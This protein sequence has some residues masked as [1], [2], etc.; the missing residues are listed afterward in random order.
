MIFWEDDKCGRL[1]L[2]LEFPAGFFK[3]HLKMIGAVR[4]F[5]LNLQTSFSWSVHTTT[6]QFS[7]P[8]CL[9]TVHILLISEHKH[10]FSVSQFLTL[11]TFRSFK[12]S[13]LSCQSFQGLQ[14]HLVANRVYCLYFFIFNFP[15]NFWNQMTKLLVWN[16]DWGY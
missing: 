4:N 11:W 6:F 2:I 8:V 7:T 1:F 9:S 3:M 16:L 15:K 12:S 10:I 5:L 13:V 14:C